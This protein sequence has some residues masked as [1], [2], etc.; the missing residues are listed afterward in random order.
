MGKMK[1]GHLSPNLAW[2]AYT[3][4]LW[5]SAGFGLGTMTNDVEVTDT[6]LDKEDYASLNAFGVASTLKKGGENYTLLLEGWA[7]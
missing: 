2:L 3:H 6:L 4:K 1:N 7:W 5:P